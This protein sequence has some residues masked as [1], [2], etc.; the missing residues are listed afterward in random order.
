MYDMDN[1]PLIA[2]NSNRPSLKRFSQHFIN[3]RKY[4]SLQMEKCYSS[5]IAILLFCFTLGFYFFFIISDW[6]TIKYR[7]TIVFIPPID[8]L[9]STNK[10]R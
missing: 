9:L 4:S 3:K 2:D 10:G 8:N 6:K 5:K 1:K 7:P